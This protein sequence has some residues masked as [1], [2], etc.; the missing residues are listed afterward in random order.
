M[1]ETTSIINDVHPQDEINGKAVRTVNNPIYN[2]STVLFETYEDLAAA[3]CGK[4]RGL[5]YGTERLPS[6]REFEHAMCTLENGFLTRAFQSGISAITNTLL[7]F[8][9]TGDH[10]IIC[11]NVYWPTSNFCNKILTKFG[12]EISYAPSAM[13]ED[14][15]EFIRTNTVL[16]FMESPGSNT[17]EI[18]DI[19]AITTVARHKNIVTVLDGT[20]ATP[21]YLRPLDLGVDISIQSITKYIAGHS[22]ILLGSVTVNEKYG[23]AFADYYKTSEIFASPQD[24][25][26]ALRGLMTLAVRL[27]QHEQSALTVAR[28]LLDNPLIGTVIHPAL[29]NH[30]QHLLWKKYFSGSSGLFSFTFAT[31]PTQEKLAAFIDTLKL[32]GIGYSWGGFKSLITAGK[33]GRTLS[34]DYS[35]KTVIRLNIGLEDPN[36]LYDDLEQAFTALSS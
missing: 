19:E 10:I 7:A 28:L 27:K 8:T 36:D 25:H 22:D 6:Q 20:W 2:A 24:C 31:E 29:T 18:Q 21:L 3:N 4:Y 13:G 23:Q 30:P 35:D 15:E 17:L 26:M 32:F 1:K 11:D 5:T 14:I 9:K 16:I 34:S 33:Y 12:V